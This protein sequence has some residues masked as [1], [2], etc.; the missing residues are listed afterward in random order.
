MVGP[1]T[2]GIAGFTVH[3]ML[4]DEGAQD[5]ESGMLKPSMALRISG[6]VPDCPEGITTR[7][8]PSEKENVLRFTLT[9]AGALVE[10]LYTA[11]PL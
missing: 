7:E 9:V 6:A 10:G 2:V 8:V 4:P 1:L 11:S 5:N 3:P